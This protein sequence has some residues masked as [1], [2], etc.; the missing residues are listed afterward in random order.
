M[1]DPIVNF[2]PSSRRATNTEPQNESELR[3]SMT[4][5]NEG[6]SSARYS[7]VTAPTR[8]SRNMPVTWHK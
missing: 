2:K 8:G 4:T 3:A 6:A 1:V 5:P 7:A